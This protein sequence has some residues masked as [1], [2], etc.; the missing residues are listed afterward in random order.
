MEIPL[1]ITFKNTEHSEYIEKEIQKRAEKLEKFFDHII[2][3]RVVVDVPH[4]HRTKGNQYDIRIDISVPNNEIVV[5][6]STPAPKDEHK[7]VHLA[8]KDAFN[9]AIRQLEDYARKVRGEVKRHE[10]PPQGII[11][12]INK[13]EGYGRIST[14]D[15]RSVYFHKNSVVGE[16]FEKLEEGMAVRFF[17]EQGDK[18][19]QAS[20]VRVIR[21]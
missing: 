11:T 16:S 21:S 15:G 2:S 20:S 8:I 5:T 10:S 19:P 14:H 7:N 17:E 4:K 18:G 1:L 3:C 6:K 12:E 13:E 9:A